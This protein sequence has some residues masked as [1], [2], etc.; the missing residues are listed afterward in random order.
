[1]KACLGP[2]WSQRRENYSHDTIHSI[3]F[4]GPNEPEVRLRENYIE[5]DKEWLLSIDVDAPASL[6]TPAEPATSSDQ[7]AP[8][9]PSDQP[10][11]TPAPP[12]VQPDVPNAPIAPP[13]TY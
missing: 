13:S 7:P 11:T 1:V 3:Y 5:T 4:I 12:T 9:P 10:L 6:A 2:N 8:A